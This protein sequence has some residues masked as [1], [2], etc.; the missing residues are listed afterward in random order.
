MSALSPTTGLPLPMV[1]TIPSLATG[2]L[3]MLRSQQWAYSSVSNA[4]RPGQ[5]HGSWCKVQACTRRGALILNL[6]LIQ[7]PSDKLAGVLQLKQ[8][9]WPLMQLSPTFHK[10]WL[11]VLGSIQQAAQGFAPR[12]T[13]KQH[14]AEPYRCRIAWHR[15]L[16]VRRR[17]EGGASLGQHLKR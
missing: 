2:Y 6:K 17:P 11:Y 10:P 8:Q 5:T 9:L 15:L 14:Q 13:P 16:P 12:C 3:R 4:C 1:A 7:L